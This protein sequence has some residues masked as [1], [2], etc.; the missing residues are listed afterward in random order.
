[1]VSESANEVAQR[2]LADYRRAL[3]GGD[4]EPFFAR[5]DDN[6]EIRFPMGRFRGEHVGMAAAR[7]LFPQ[8]AQDFPGGIEAEGVERV[9]TD[10]AR[11]V[12]EMGSSD[13]RRGQLY[14][15]RV[16]IVMEICGGKVCAY[17]EYF[18]LAGSPPES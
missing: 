14:R 1:V 7:E 9:T 4:W 11:V 18:G 6:I 12:F 5:L 17:R 15:N 16:A 13:K 8:V 10:G 3:T 2:A